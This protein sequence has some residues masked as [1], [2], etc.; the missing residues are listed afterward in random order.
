MIEAVPNTIEQ[1]GRMSESFGEHPGSFPRGCLSCLSHRQGKI[2]FVVQQDGKWHRGI[3]GHNAHEVKVAV[4]PG[5]YHIH[6]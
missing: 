1:R 5:T 3:R 4:V 2:F 6:G